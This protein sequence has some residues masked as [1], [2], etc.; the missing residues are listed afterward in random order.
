M[1]EY[2][3][4]SESTEPK[5]AI[6]WG[7]IISSGYQYLKTNSYSENQLLTLGRYLQTISTNSDGWGDGLLEAI[8][9]KKDF[10][11]K[12]YIDVF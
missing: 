1:L 9:L 3:F 8:G 10:V 6:L 7:I 4:L 5:L 12:K 2:S 11:T